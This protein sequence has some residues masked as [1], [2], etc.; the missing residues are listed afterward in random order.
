LRS[1]LRLLDSRIA[2][3]RSLEDHDSPKMIKKMEEEVK[4]SQKRIEELKSE[5]NAQDTKW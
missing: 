2:I 1:K 4:E 5:I 3:A